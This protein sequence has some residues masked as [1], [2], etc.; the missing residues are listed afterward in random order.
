ME[1]TDYRVPVTE[2]DR[3]RAGLAMQLVALTFDVPVTTMTGDRLGG[4]ACRGRWL[5]IYLA[6]VGY[7]WTLERVSHAFA[8]NR[9]TA[10]AGVARLLISECGTLG[11]GV[12]RKINH[13]QRRGP[14]GGFARPPHP[15]R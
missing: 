1:A 5:A 6:H 9:T 8:V 12:R 2:G 3:T 10:S 4:K 13:P 14:Q 7:G 15:R 11:F